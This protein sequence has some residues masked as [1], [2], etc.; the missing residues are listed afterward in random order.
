VTKYIEE[1]YPGEEAPVRILQEKVNAHIG[2]GTIA[3][4]AGVS[5]LVMRMNVRRR[6]AAIVNHGANPAT[7]TLIGPAAANL[8]IYLAANGGS[9]T[10]GE[11]TDFKYM[12]EVYGFSTLGTT[13]G[14][15]ELSS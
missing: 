13:L 7:I 8:G 6:S 15:V 3:L 14:I 2:A 9:F 1:Q 11:D 12:G 4:A 10:F 5:A